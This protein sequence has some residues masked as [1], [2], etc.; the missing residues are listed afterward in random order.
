[1]SNSRVDL[2]SPAE[3]HRDTQ[4]CHIT[5]TRWEFCLSQENNKRMDC[6]STYLLSQSVLISLCGFHS[7]LVISGAGEAANNAKHDK[8]NVTT[9][10]LYQHRGSICHVTHRSGALAG[11]DGRKP[12]SRPRQKRGRVL[13][14]QARISAI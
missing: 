5:V 6:I 4:R 10:I 13:P 9:R 14:S 3:L 1:M 2:Y 11:R 8:S 12:S 7:M